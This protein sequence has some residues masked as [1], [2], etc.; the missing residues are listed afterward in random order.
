MII[1]DLSSTFSVLSRWLFLYSLLLRILSLFCITST[2]PDLQSWASILLAFCM[3]SFP[4][5]YI[6][7]F[8]KAELLCSGVLDK[9]KG[10]PLPIEWV[11]CCSTVLIRKGEVNLTGFLYCLCFILSVPA[12][13]FH[14]LKTPTL[15]WSLC[16]T[17]N[18]LKPEDKM[19]QAVSFINVKTELE[20][21]FLSLLCIKI[22]R[23]ICDNKQMSKYRYRTSV[24]SSVN[25]IYA[26]T[27]EILETYNWNNKKSYFFLHINIVLY[28][29]VTNFYL[30]KILISSSEYLNLLLTSLNQL[31][32]I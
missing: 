5:S 3:T 32:W 15:F 29:T 25:I 28:M 7:Y 16:N 11:K 18:S 24:N 13:T 20:G 12:R 26:R 9:S 31:Q 30:Q 6:L 2:L 4:L 27:F 14:R 10:C 23:K 17:L 22:R 21:R 1:W 19:L 8:S